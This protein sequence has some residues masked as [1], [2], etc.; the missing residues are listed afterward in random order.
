MTFFVGISILS[1]MY[2]VNM[3]FHNI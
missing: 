3:Q 1:L 2:Y